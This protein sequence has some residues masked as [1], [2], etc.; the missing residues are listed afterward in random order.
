MTTVELVTKIFELCLFPLLG[1]LTA[2]AVALIRKKTEEIKQTT[3]NELYQKYLTMLEE[4]VINCVIATNQ[5]YV[6]TLKKEGKFD[7]EAQKVAFERTYKAV[8][9]ILAKDAQVYL[10]EAIGDL[11]TYISELIEATVNQNKLFIIDTA[12]K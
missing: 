7:V 12:E 5:T 3:D 1:V 4:T 11:N 2:Y 9:T 8:L 6:E 10:S